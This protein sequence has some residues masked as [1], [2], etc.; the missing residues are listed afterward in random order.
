MEKNQLAYSVKQVAARFGVGRATI[1]KRIREGTV[2]AYKVGRAWRIDAGDVE[3]L[4][5]VEQAEPVEQS[6]DGGAL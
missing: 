2:D 3:K 1:M 4:K 6:L 5:N